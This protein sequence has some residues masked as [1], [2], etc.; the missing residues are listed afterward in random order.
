MK[1]FETKFKQLLSGSYCITPTQSKANLGH[2][3]ELA[4]ELLVD[5]QIEQISTNIFTINNYIVAARTGAC[6]CQYHQRCGKLCKHSIAVRLHLGLSLDKH[7]SGPEDEEDDNALIALLTAPIP[8]NS[9]SSH[10]MHK[11]EDVEEHCKL[12][13]IPLPTTNC[14]ERRYNALPRYAKHRSQCNT[15][16]LE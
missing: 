13:T 5:N 11:L 12:Y 16:Y 6:T 2:H 4:C 15:K 14:R 9:P 7:T 10:H 1:A 3:V 8:A